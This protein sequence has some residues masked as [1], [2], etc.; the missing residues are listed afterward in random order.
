MM[1]VSAALTCEKTWENTNK[2]QHNYHRVTLLIW[3][4]HILFLSADRSGQD[5]IEALF[6]KSKTDYT[7]KRS[8]NEFQFMT[9]KVSAA[10]GRVK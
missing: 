8:G 3:H 9:N 1:T 5:P 7:Y 2:L 4:V 10:V 6:R